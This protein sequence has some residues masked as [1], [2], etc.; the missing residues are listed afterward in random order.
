MKQFVIALAIAA[1]STMAFA[2]DHGTTGHGKGRR[3]DAHMSRFA[4]KLGLSEAQKQQMAEIRKADAEKNRQLYADFRAKKQ[5]L[6]QAKKSND[7]NFDAM[8]AQFESLKDQ[9]KAAK[10]A[11]HAQML[12]VLT[13]DQR[14][15]LEQ[16]KSRKN[17]R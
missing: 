16:M 5:A 12:T 8:K 7:P 9:V 17:R 6:M 2:H 15:Q 14:A 10:E 13:A 11:V 1:T 3:G 4:E